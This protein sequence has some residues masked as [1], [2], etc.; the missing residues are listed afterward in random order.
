[1]PPKKGYSDKEKI[2]YYKRRAMEAERSGSKGPKDAYYYKSKRRMYKAKIAA[3]AASRAPRERRPAGIISEMGGEVGAM[4][5][6]PIPIVGPIVGRFLGGKLGHLVEQITGFGDY[7][8][9]SNSVMKGGLTPP[10]VV[11]SVNKGSIIVRHREYIGD[12]NASS[13]FT[14]TSYPINP[15][16]SRTFPWLSGIAVNF[17]QYR[18]RGCLFEFLS[19]SSDS[20]LAS[21]A[22]S[23]LGTVNMAT[24]YDS[25][26][27]NFT[28]KRE[29]LN[30]EFAN[31]RKPSVSFIHPIECKKSI[32]PVSELYVRPHAVPSGADQRLYD[33]GKFQIAT[34]GMQAS[35]GVVGELWVTYEVEFFK[36]KY[37]IAQLS[38]GLSDHFVLSGVTNS[39]PLGTTT[40]PS[41]TSTLGGTINT[42][43]RAYSFPSWISEGRW[44]ICYYCVGTANVVA[45]PTLTYTNCSMVSIF[46]NGTNGY[47]GTSAPANTTTITTLCCVD[48]TGANATVQWSTGTL[49]SSVTAGDI[50]VTQ[51]TYG[52][53]VPQILTDK[54]VNQLLA[55]ETLYED[56]EPT[57]VQNC[58]LELELAKRETEELREQI[59]L[60]RTLVRKDSKT[61]L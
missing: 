26:E 46:H 1:M 56:D 21:S 34:E 41:S 50:I 16:Q 35:T 40:S 59:N 4:L 8:I 20:I 47:V 44:L 52:L 3:E 53:T 11:N 2:A 30:H 9:G 24:E 17:E 37:D 38:A 33:L 60:L 22:T 29:M 31:S 39:L 54:T 55:A 23:A 19:T 13:A 32:T 43:T 14:L 6:G 42:L 58:K 27:Q 25:L 12:I 15:G 45:T 10:Q 5:G 36:A 28:G 49:P 51:L 57:L 7:K 48:V 61:T 18:M